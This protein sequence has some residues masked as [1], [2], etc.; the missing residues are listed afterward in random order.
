MAFD[1]ITEEDLKDKGVRGLPDIPQLTTAEMQAKFEELETAVIIPKLNK[2]IDDLMAETAG[3]SIGVTVPDGFAAEKNIQSLLSEMA[4]IV[5]AS[6]SVNMLLDGIKSVS[7]TVV[8]DAT[9]LA[10]CKAVC[11]YVVQM[12]GGDM[13]KSTYDTNAN[14]VVDN[15]EKLGG[16]SAEEYVA[17]EDIIDSLEEV[18]ATTEAGLPAGALA[19]KAVN[20][21]IKGIEFQIT[22]GK[23]QFRY[24]KEVYPDA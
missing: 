7:N 5:L 6:K 14:G 13:A 3:E 21:K 17:K 20:A 1:K 24:D 12:G 10:T 22:G 19:V 18:E 4:V 8:D 15:S 11:D 2:L 16:K 9:A 23:L